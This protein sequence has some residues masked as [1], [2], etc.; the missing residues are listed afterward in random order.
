M[1]NLP[2]ESLFRNA[3]RRVLARSVMA[4]SLAFL[5]AGCACPPSRYD[6]R[7]VTVSDAEAEAL[8]ELD[9]SAGGIDLPTCITHCGSSVKVDGEPTA[10]VACQMEHVQP[11]LVCEYSYVCEGAG[12]RP[13][14][15]ATDGAVAAEDPVASWLGRVAH[16]ESAA[17]LAF[18]ALI[19]ELDAHGAPMKLRAAARRAR[20]DE[21]EHALTFTALA[22]AHGVEPA[23]AEATSV[24][25]RSLEQIALDNAAEG[26]VGE[27]YGALSL[28]W[29]S[30]AAPTEALRRITRR[31]ARDEAR[32]AALSWRLDTWLRGRLDAE[33][34]RRMD[35]ARD[36]RRAELAAQLALPTAP[37]LVAELGVPRSDEALSLL[38][39]VLPAA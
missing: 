9:A 23:R 18:D 13:P 10:T 1:A 38:D 3:V 7:L 37:E 5:P 39:S 34:R 22:R 6:V 33:V 4:G 29:M 26:C 8:R 36:A 21:V 15:L 11:R 32:H 35:G 28:G 16:L 19:A 25:L 12:R 30:Y 24:G 14:G 2:Y 27:T 20:G 17:V 31:V